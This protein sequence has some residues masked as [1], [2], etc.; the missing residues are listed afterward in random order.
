MT[1]ILLNKLIC[2]IFGHSKKRSLF[3]GFGEV[4]TLDGKLL[5]THK[6][7]NIEMCGRCN[8]QLNKDE[9]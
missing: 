1:I 7:K 9:T 2:K 3:F 6:S 5:A 4:R 8:K